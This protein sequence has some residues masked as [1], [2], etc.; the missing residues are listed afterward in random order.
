MIRPGYFVRQAL[1]GMRA[2]PMIQLAA[3]GAIAVGLLLVGVAVV[4]ALNVERLAN[5][6]GRGTQLTVYLKQDA[7][8]ARADALAKL[9]R[10]RH[11][12]A[13]VRYIS[14][15][16]ARKRLGE[17][18]GSR[19]ALLA[20][21][22]PDFLPASLEVELSREA[23]GAQARAIVALLGA[24]RGVE[25][26][27]YLGRWAQRLGTLV[28]LMRTGAIL[29]AAIIALACLYIVGS[30][31]RLGVYA[32][33]E[34]IE[35][36]QLVGA[37]PAFVRAPFMLEGALQGLVGGA[38]AL[39]ALY[40]FHSIAAPEIE[41]ALASLLA[42]LDVAFLSPLQLCLGLVGGVLLGLVGSTVATGRYVEAA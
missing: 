12:V 41:G 5:H 37:T 8:R 29:V 30:T 28:G 38:L 18:L 27:D 34:E 36:Q 3:V 22:E 42:R 19:A 39:L 40:V 20:D 31:I 6:W 33:R 11:E 2:K 21:V 7:T 9:L 15:R 16:D 35:I 14:P 25:E 17:S 13:R 1:R 24:A 23:D 4:C 32:R 10:S 26:V